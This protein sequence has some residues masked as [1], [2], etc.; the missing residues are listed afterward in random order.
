[1]PASGAIPKEDRLSIRIPRSIK[2]DLIRA[3]TIS[4]VTLGDFVIAS[5][6]AAAVNIIQSH[7]LMKLSARDYDRLMEALDEP[8]K[9]NSAL[10]KAARDYKKAIAD[11]DLTIED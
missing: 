7:Q 5:T 6:S 2:E 8:P 11:G 10:L 9:P 3:A 1:M 4:G